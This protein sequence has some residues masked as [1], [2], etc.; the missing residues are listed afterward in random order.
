M[1]KLNVARRRTES[2]RTPTPE[3]SHGLDYDWRATARAPSA[4]TRP[5]PRRSSASLLPG[6]ETAPS[7]WPLH[8]AQVAEQVGGAVL[9][10]QEAVALVGL[11]PLF[12]I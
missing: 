10:L 1:P 2:P 11:E 12:I 9:R 7:R 3:F 5:S 4:R 6:N 8:G